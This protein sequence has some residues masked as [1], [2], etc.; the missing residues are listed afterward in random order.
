MIATRRFSLAI[1]AV[2]ALSACA[3]TEPERPIRSFDPDPVATPTYPAVGLNANTDITAYNPAQVV[4]PPAPA[5]SA[6]IKQK[7][8]ATVQPSKQR[9]KPAPSCSRR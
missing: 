3:V 5:A 1:V 9:G 7:C 8:P 6:P 2:S 4:P